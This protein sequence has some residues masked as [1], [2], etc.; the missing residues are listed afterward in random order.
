MELGDLV[1][2]KGERWLAT[3]FDRVARVMT[4]Y[5]AGGVKT[6]LPREFDRVHP[7]EL[8]VVASPSKQWGMLTAPC[9]GGGGGPFVKMVVT[10]M[11]GRTK[12]RVLEPW[13]D[14]IPSD[15]ARNGGSFFVRPEVKLLPGM[16][17][18]ATH[19]NGSIVRVSVPTTFGTVARRKALAEAKASKPPEQN[20]FTR[21]LGAD[22]DDET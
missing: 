2:Y 22:D 1:Q 18:L 8:Q 7:T 13:V 16:L 15:F 19:R 9:K 4:L 10:G 20:R 12:D 21:L 14:W 11:P 5:S 17:L 6:E 3:S